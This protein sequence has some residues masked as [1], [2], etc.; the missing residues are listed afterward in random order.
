MNNYSTQIKTAELNENGLAINAGWITVYHVHPETREYQSASYEYL[1][2]GVGIP[3]DSYSDEPEIPSSGLALRRS[4]DGLKWEH[5]PDYRGQTV[6]S[7][8]N[9]HPQAI[10]YLGELANDVTLIKPET[11]FDVWDGKAW[12]LDSDAQQQSLI[13][14]TKAELATRLDTANTQISTLSDAVSLGI[15]TEAE[16]AQLAAWQTYR[17]LLSRID[18]YTGP[19]INWP[20]MP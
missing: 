13:Q 9:R 2:T 1:M 15:A 16:N 20:D 12:V 11:D 4:I 7:T 18:I 5:V 14:K 3:A 17:V 19:E 8:E 6:Y 10:T